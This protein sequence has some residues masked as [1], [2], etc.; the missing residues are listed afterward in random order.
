MTAL[1]KDACIALKTG[2]TRDDVISYISKVAPNREIKPKS[3]SAMISNMC[4]DNG[5]LKIIESGTG[6]TLG[7]YAVRNKE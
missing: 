4:S 7:V 5:F 1:V 6:G 3:I 2:F